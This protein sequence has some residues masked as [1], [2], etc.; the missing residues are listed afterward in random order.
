MMVV[1]HVPGYIVSNALAAAKLPTSLRVTLGSTLGLELDWSTSQ[2]AS[3]LVIAANSTRCTE[4]MI[5]TEP[6]HFLS[7]Q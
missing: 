4:L 5:V 3:R 2:G 1:L 7:V 6:V